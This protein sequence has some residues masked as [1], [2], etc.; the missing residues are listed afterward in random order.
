MQ[1]APAERAPKEEGKI[2]RG[3]KAFKD[4][5]VRTADCTEIRTTDEEDEW[6]VKIFDMN[7]TKKDGKRT[8]RTSWSI[9]GPGIDSTILQWY[10]HYM[11]D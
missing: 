4:I 7:E 8:G 10:H 3:M 5:N 1:K 11:I 9:Y 2:H 6:A